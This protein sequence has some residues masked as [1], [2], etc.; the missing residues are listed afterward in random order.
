[1]VIG[2]NDEPFSVLLVHVDDRFLFVVSVCRPEPIMLN[3][4]QSNPPELPHSEYRDVWSQV[5]NPNHYMPI[6]TP[7]YPA[8]NSSYNVSTHTLEVMK[9]EFKRGYEITQIIIREKGG[10]GWHRLFEHTDF[11]IKYSHYLQCHI[12]GNGE[13]PESR[14]WIGFVESRL[15]R[16]IPF[17]ETLPLKMPI[18]LYPVMSK[19]QKSN[20]S[21]CYFIG[22]NLDMDAI[23]AMTDKNIHIN[24]CVYRFQ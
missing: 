2:K 21:V 16:F 11:F 15:R 4:I 1:M 17:L 5:N 23:S 10:E 19:T 12:V 9:Q 18:Q 3:N 7:A 20:F 22:F 8:M 24:E 13:N 6:I 14:S